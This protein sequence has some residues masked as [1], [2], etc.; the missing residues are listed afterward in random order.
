MFGDYARLVHRPASP[1]PET[2]SS[3]AGWAQEALALLTALPGAR[4]VG[5][6]LAEGGGRRLRFT[7]GDRDRGAG[8]EWCHVD[9]YDDVPLNTAIR[10]GSPVA[11]GLDDLGEAYG[12][13]VGRQDRAATAALAAVPVVTAGQVLGGFVVFFDRPQAF[14]HRQ[15]RQLARL[16]EDLGAALRRAQRSWERPRVGLSDEP[17]P[18]GAEAAVHEVGPGS[19]AVGEAR[20]FLER[21]LGGWG[22]DE[23]ATAAAVLCLSELVTNA[24]VH[25][26]TG[27]SVRTLLEGRVLTTTVRDGGTAHAAAAESVEDPLRVHGRGLQLVEAFSTRWGS[28]LDA[29]GTTVWFVLELG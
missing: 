21:T 18:T 24:L 11:G 17:V 7:A 22:I 12:A 8:L 25:A 2:I 14:D 4:R 16:G 27:C 13:F 3:D 15:R 9:A 26:H 1:A 23:E 6:A 29:A 28:E 19:E 20:R 10:T 5:L